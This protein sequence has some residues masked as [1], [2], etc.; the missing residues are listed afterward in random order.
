MT[1]RSNPGD[2]MRKDKHRSGGKERTWTRLRRRHAAIEPRLGRTTNAITPPQDHDHRSTKGKERWGVYNTL[3]R[4]EADI[5]SL[6]GMKTTTERCRQKSRRTQ[7]SSH[8][9]A[10]YI[11]QGNGGGASTIW[12]GNTLQCQ[13]GQL[14]SSHHKGTKSHI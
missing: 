3:T 5:T 7:A 6:L 12:D 1:K 10:G 9:Q 11:H 14:Q 13:S 4:V 8:N 2:K